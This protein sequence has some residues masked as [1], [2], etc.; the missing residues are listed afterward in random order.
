MFSQLQLVLISCFFTL[1]FINTLWFIFLFFLFSVAFTLNGSFAFSHT[2]S[3]ITFN[4]ISDF[5]PVGFKLK[6]G[7]VNLSDVVLC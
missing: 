1:H 7:K 2:V 5:F 4:L 6:T 3:K